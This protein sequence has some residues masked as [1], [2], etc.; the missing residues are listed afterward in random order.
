MGRQAQIHQEFSSR[1]AGYGLNP[2]RAFGT[3]PKSK[4]SEKTG[5]NNAGRTVNVNGIDYKV[6]DDGDTLIPLK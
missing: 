2:G 4:P 6:G 3:P 5:K 1:A